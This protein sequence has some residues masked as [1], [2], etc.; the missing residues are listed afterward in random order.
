MIKKHKLIAVFTVLIT[1]VLTLNTM[2]FA[3]E[4]KKDDYDK[5]IES[6]G[7]VGASL[8]LIHNGKIE[9]VRN[10]GY[11]DLAQK[12][13]VTNDTAFKIASISKSVTAYAVMQLVEEGKLN[14]DTPVDN[15]LTRWHLPPSQ[16]DN[17][18]VTLRT[19]MSHTSGVSDSSEEGYTEPLPDIA[20]A[21]TQRNI[22]LLREPGTT[23][24]Y[25]G[26]A[27]FGICQLV[28][29][30]VTGQKYE[31]YMT[32]YVFQ[33]LGMSNTSFANSGA[34]LA[35]HYGANN[36]AEPTEPIVMNAADGIT[37]TSTDLAKL[38]IAMMAYKND[39]N[40]E[41]FQLQK[42][43]ES[44]GGYGLGINIRTLSDGRTTYDHK[45]VL[46]GWQVHMVF[47]PQSQN[48]LVILTNSDQGY[49][50]TNPLIQQWSTNILGEAVIDPFNYQLVQGTNIVALV[51]C[52]IAALALLVMI[53]GLIRKKLRLKK[54]HAVG[55]FMVI[56]SALLFCSLWYTLFY[57]NIPKELIDR[58]L[59]NMGLDC[60]PLYSYLP[61]SLLLITI[62]MV[63]L[64]ILAIVRTRLT[65]R[66]WVR[67]HH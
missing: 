37:T 32:K 8:A 52:V 53:I 47:E 31:D 9:E 43:T 19:L 30:E 56:V 67:K 38:A 48:G 34:N 61:S 4:A 20:T 58:Y 23:F 35:S 12:K 64:W 60:F 39:T 42:N 14:L 36:K 55:T 1:A 15:Y 28:I 5:I 33:K 65:R 45:G 2:V 10:Y 17:S 16:F 7:P 50:L 26:N 27:G 18:K 57:T 63:F 13:P 54:G 51:L 6:Y 62:A 49:A 41:M 44:Q 46:T 25:S 59:P 66:H 3:E 22:H 29:E 21:L 40:S 11:A 24:E